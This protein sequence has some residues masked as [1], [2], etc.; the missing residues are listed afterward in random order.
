MKQH[1]LFVLALFSAFSAFAQSPETSPA[2]PLNFITL[3]PE[4]G[5]NIT[6]TSATLSSDI[7]LYSTKQNRLH[8]YVRIGW[9]STGV[10]FGPSGP[11]GK[12]TLQMLT[13]AHS[14]HLELS[15]GIWAGNNLGFGPKGIYRLPI[16]GFGYRFQPPK[17]GFLFRSFLELTGFG[18]GVGWAF[19]VK[20]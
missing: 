18:I 4:I 20:K 7:H 5:S 13:G 1:T 8:V 12:A 2:G 11:G 15:G 6:Y 19:R 16:F 9:G 3:Y 17:G 14:H 10:R